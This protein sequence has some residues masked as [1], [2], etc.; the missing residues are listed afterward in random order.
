MLLCEESASID[1]AREMRGIDSIAKAV[2]LAAASALVVRGLVSGARKPIRTEPAP[3][4]PISASV[5]G[6]ILTTTSDCH[7]SAASAVIR[8]PACA[9]TAS[10]SS[11]SAPAPFSTRTSTPLAC[12]LATTSGTSATLCS[13]SAISFGTPTRMKAGKVSDL[14][15]AT[16][17]GRLHAP[18]DGQS[19][20]VQLDEIGLSGCAICETRETMTVNLTRI[21][22]KG[23]DGGETHLGDMS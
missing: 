4:R 5:G 15:D 9:K 3:S 18:S 10:G 1:W 22:T 7:T 8:A 21:Y 19:S 20:R 12:D 23:G 13:P 16:Q 14:P 17:S 2:A 11:A 6:E